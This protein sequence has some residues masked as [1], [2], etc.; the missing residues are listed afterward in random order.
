MGRRNARLTPT[1]RYPAARRIVG[2]TNHS[3]RGTSWRLLKI[4]RPCFGPLLILNQRQ[5][6]RERESAIQREQLAGS[7]VLLRIVF[8]FQLRSRKVVICN[9]YSTWN[10]ERS[11]QRRKRTRRFRPEL[12]V[13]PADSLVPNELQDFRRTARHFD[14]L[15]KP[16]NA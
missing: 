7:V 4:F 13:R 10:P 5:E 3:A 16:L 6:C 11:T 1:C 9:S 15:G 8:E 12:N 14:L 2:R